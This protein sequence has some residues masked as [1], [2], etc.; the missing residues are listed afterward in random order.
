MYYKQM[1]HKFQAVMREQQQMEVD[2][3]INNK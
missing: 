2:K 1:V 3:K